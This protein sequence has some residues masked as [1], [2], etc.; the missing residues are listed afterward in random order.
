MREP[1]LELEDQEPEPDP[2]PEPQLLPV[3]VLAEQASHSARTLARPAAGPAKSPPPLRLAVNPP[4]LRPRSGRL[5]G[6]TRVA[7]PRERIRDL[8]S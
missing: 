5:Q 7:D 1:V 8:R 6:C 3:D 4:R 2:D